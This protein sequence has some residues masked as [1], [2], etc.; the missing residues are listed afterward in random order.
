MYAVREA[1]TD[2][3]DDRHVYQAGDIY[4]R[5]GY[6][7]TRARLKELLSSDNKRGRPLIAEYLV[8]HSTAA[9]H[10]PERKTGRG[11]TQ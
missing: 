2:V 9:P 6:K 10:S 3:R 4:P 8:R 1:F 5:P 7:P 11:D